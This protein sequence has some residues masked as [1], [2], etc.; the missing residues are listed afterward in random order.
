MVNK[1]EKMISEMSLRE[2]VG[3]MVLIRAYDYR[4]KILTMLSSGEISGLGAIVITQKGT[5]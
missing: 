1:V 2:K 5:R 4:E 3:Q